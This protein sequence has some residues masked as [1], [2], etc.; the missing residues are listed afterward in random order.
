M[1]SIAKLIINIYTDLSDNEFYTL[2]GEYYL[3]QTESEEVLNV[4]KDPGKKKKSKANSKCMYTNLSFSVGLVYV[5]AVYMHIHLAC[6]FPFI[7]AVKRLHSS[8]NF[9]TKGLKQ[10][11]VQ[12]SSKCRKYLHND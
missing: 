7:L 10:V 1:L 12:L 2:L 9:K 8:K 11:P 6:S 3:S 4:E 5:I